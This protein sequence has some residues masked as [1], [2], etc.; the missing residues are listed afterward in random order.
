M[1]KKSIKKEE[2]KKEEFQGNLT[3]N[4]LNKSLKELHKTIYWQSIKQ[5]NRSV[6]WAA[7][8]SLRTTDAFKEPTQ[9]ARTQ[10][11]ITGLYQLE[12]YVEDLVKPKEE[13]DIPKY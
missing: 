9:M 4:E 2:E 5:Y 12:N 6:L 11:I 1:K 13:E 7:D 10:G 8:S 3:D